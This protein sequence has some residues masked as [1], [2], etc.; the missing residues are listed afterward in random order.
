MERHCI[1]HTVPTTVFF[2]QNGG[3]KP[4]AWQLVLGGR[5]MG[6]LGRVQTTGWR[7]IGGW[8]MRR[9]LPICSDT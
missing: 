9:L 7:S 6:K 4:V 3:V 1:V 8:R 2:V 5:S